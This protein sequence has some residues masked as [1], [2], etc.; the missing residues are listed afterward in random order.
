MMVSKHQL[1]P[2]LEYTTGRKRV[3]H[4]GDDNEETVFIGVFENPYKISVVV[5]KCV[6]KFVYIRKDTFPILKN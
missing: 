5:R 1:L 4:D 6:S 2:P 3:L